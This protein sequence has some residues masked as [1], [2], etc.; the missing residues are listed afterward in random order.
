VREL[1]RLLFS[2]LPI[3]GHTYPLLPL[4]IAAQ[5]A[6]H[7]VTFAT[8]PQFQDELTSYGMRPA[9]S[10]MTI[11]DAFFA[12]LKVRFGTDQP[13]TLS[14]DQL[15]ELPFTA[16]GRII[17]GRV[18][19]QTGELI[20]GL[21]PD[22]VVQEAGNYGAGLA[23]RLAG[24]PAVCH[25][26]S[27]ESPDPLLLGIEDELRTF[28]GEIGIELAEGRIGGL[29]NPYIDIY[30]P[31]LQDQ[32]FRDTMKIIELRPVP[33]S[34]ATE[35]PDWV[36][37]RG[38][39]RPRVYLTLGTML[40]G[41]VE[42]LRHALDGVGALDADVVTSTGPTMDVSTLGAVPANVTMHKW[43]PQS[44]LLHHVDLVVHHGGAGTTLGAFSVGV[45]QVVLP[46]G[47]DAFANA[48]AV[49]TSGAGLRLLPDEVSGASVAHAAR[50]LLEDEAQ[51]AAATAAAR[52]VADE[53]AA[54]PG[55]DE[56][57]ARL[58]EFAG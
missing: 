6:G 13:Q 27:R 39:T 58:P 53:I 56:V 7:E 3:H 2:S 12:A 17:P 43:V 41:T 32:Q 28:A 11:Y 26:F 54:M 22:L 21:K 50:T 4:A 9:E 25:G 45:P 16:F 46:L 33:T 20:S 31:S 48:D 42:V 51:R 18:I 15:R 29:G 10:G 1:V 37:D 34:G 14:E 5:R 49:V 52:R 30:P 55:P 24:V 8:G 35:V 36:R 40:G 47:A 57:A 19:E 44:E 38:R 23:A